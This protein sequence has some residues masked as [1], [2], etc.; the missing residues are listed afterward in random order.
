MIKSVQFNVY[1]ES[2]MKNNDTRLAIKITL[3]YFVFAGAWILLS[4]RL[5]AILVP[6]PQRL[7]ELEEAKGIIFV[8]VTTLLLFSL[9]IQ[10][11][12]VRRQAEQGVRQMA[13]IIET[14]NDAIISKTLD[15]TILS[16]N[17]A[18][19][20][21]YGYT[22]KEVIG[23]N[24]AILVPPD[25]P[26]E[27]PSILEKIR[28]GER[29]EPY[30]TERIRK[31]GQRLFISLSISPITD[32]QGKA[33]A[34]SAIARNITERRRQEMELEAVAN[35]ANALRSTTTSGEMLP[36]VLHLAADLLGA[37]G[38]S[39]AL[40]EPLSGETVIEMAT[41]NLS[42]SS[43]K[44]LAPGEGISGQVILTGEAYVNPNVKDDPYFQQ[45]Y[46]EQPVIAVV[47]VPLIAQ[48]NAVGAM[49][50]SKSIP[51][52]EEE[53]RVL[54]AIADIAASALHRV[55]LLEQ[56]E[57]SLQRL[58]ALHTIDEAI[59]SSLNLK[60][61][62]GVLLDQVTS[63]LDVD[64]ASVML[65]NPH[66][67]LLEYAAWRGFR[68][69]DFFRQIR[70]R[71]GEGNAGRAALEGQVVSVPDLRDQ[72]KQGQGFLTEE[73]V[74]YFY[75][76]RDEGFIAYY[77][78]PLVAKASVK[79]IL[80]IFH[81]GHLNPSS[82]WMSFLAA[83][84][85]QAA[86]AIDNASLLEDLQRA[87]RELARSYDITLE[88]WVRTL[89]LRD[90]ETEYHSQ[91]VTETTIQLAQA[92]GMEEIDL[93]SIRRGA[94]LHDIGKMGVPDSILL[95]PGPLTVEE[96][97]VMR[98]HPIYAYELLSPISYLRPALD[99]PY[100]HHERW[101]GSGYPRGISG[102]QIP[103]AA[104]LFAVVDVWDALSSDRPY[105]PAWED[106]AIFDYIQQESGKH[107]DPEAVDLFFRKILEG[108][109]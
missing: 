76:V 105:R 63:R 92:A 73:Q 78:V 67:Y 70:L 17:P 99:I 93:D 61:V 57:Q 7:V 37:D 46:P 3:A 100:C 11:L 62:L 84:G 32:G 81:R 96:R 74:Q 58:A 19:E 106:E 59:S 30:E 89:N 50:I 4:D 5:L 69:Q 54:N 68:R 44:R 86:I 71:L 109:D 87:N 79:G 48:N 8:I 52:T 55:I 82:E 18:A 104:R 90:H 33:V 20:E 72:I 14:S 15:G 107:F 35:I 43:G 98:M 91:R 83:L 13:S 9:L 34:A 53:M 56:A 39:I 6:N 24:I 77:A 38:A 75:A 66:T 26:D 80:E 88:G 28:R 27:L 40:P 65:L 102:K 29:V 12:N 23:K 10:G 94:L 85:K 45:G 22:A 16:W 25:R 2:D 49:W 21:I 51:L 95:K 36:V 47:C 60:V 41:G 101:D 97:E 108:Q 1:D 64:A 31:D 103:L 42:Y